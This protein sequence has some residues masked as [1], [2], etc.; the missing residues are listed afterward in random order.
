MKKVRTLIVDDEAPARGDL[1]YILEEIPEA[2]V[3]GE[4][5]SAREALTWLKANGPVDMIFLDIEMPGMNGLEA[6][7]AVS[8]MMPDMAVVFSTGFSQFAVQ[9]FELEAFD[10]I[11]KPYRDER[12][13]R[14]VRRF[15]NARKEEAANSTAGEVIFPQKRLAIAADDKILF[16][17]PAEEIAMIKTEKGG[18]TLFYTT[19]GVIASKLLL[20]DME[21]I[22]APA[23][24]CR[25]HKSY[26]VNLNMIREME[27]WF[28]D[29]YLLIMAHFEKE[30]VPVSRHYLPRFRELVHL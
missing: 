30:E 29:T 26:V 23:G 8:E 9:A 22:L 6:A 3:A 13:A 12:V 28:N 19:R 7:R 25:T 21:K 11:L 1:R 14:T 16:L 17:N 2:E 4:C 15:A 10:Y 20:K 5:A 18:A 24:F 27:P